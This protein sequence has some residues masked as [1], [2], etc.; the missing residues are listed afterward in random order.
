MSGAVLALTF[1]L[2]EQGRAA[3]DAE[4]GGGVEVVSLTGLDEQARRATLGRTTVLLSRNTGTELRP[5][6]AGMIRHVRLVQFLTAGVDFIPLRDLLPEVPVASNGGAYA[7]P[8][9]EHALAMALAA[10][11]RLFVEHA[12]LAQG[13]FNQFTPNRMLAGGVCGILGFGGIGVATARLM[14][15]LGMRI[16]A[17]RRSGASEEPVDWIGGPDRLDELLAA[18]DVLVL[19]LP[20]T[21]ATR[22]LIGTRELQLMKSDAILV[23]L[24]RGEILHEQAL[25]DHL[26]ATPSFTACV[27]AWW[28]EPVRHGQFRMDLP[29]LELPNVIGSP[30][31]S[32]SVPGWREVALR[33]AAANCRR[34]LDGLPPRHLIGADERAA[35]PS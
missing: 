24:A 22:G 18:A 6:E 21:R 29:F 25:Y 15:S 14:R 34:V 12:A 27:D 16:H 23:N 33:H 7:A 10:A 13:T 1:K 26:R 28:I 4:L 31:N 17:I 30:H 5:G 20:L 3:I 11:K 35:A 19:S 8:M 9:A 2:D 32:A